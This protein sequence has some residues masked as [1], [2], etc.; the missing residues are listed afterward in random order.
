MTDKYL[1]ERRAKMLGLALA[2]EPEKKPV[3]KISI[4]SVKR[5]AEDRLYL[6]KR[7]EY[8]MSHANCEVKG[9]TYSSGEIHHR[10]G[11]IGKL[12]YD[13]KYFLAVC[14]VHHRIIEDNPNW[15]KKNKYSSSRLKNGLP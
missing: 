10:K 1:L 12:L 7:K 2:P 13:E 14:S 6:K 9:C 5:M 4:R 11:R 3:K 8:L 15:A